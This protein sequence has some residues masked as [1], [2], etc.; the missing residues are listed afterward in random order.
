MGESSSSSFSFPPMTC[1]RGSEL[2]SENGVQSSAEHGSSFAKTNNGSIE[3]EPM[4]AD[5]LAS[6]L[7]ATGTSCSDEVDGE[8]SVAAIVDCRNFVAYNVNHV[9][10]AFNASCG[11]RIAQKRLLSGKATVADFVS[12]G[13]VPEAESHVPRDHFKQLIQKS[14]ADGRII[15]AYDDNATNITSLP[16]THPLRMVTQCLMKAGAVIKFL[17]GTQAKGQSVSVEFN[18]PVG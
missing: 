12:G 5:Q 7:P 17:H 16:A 11:D 13:P 9:T 14:A 10:S 1:C 3:V 18:R 15:V 2:P 4:S 6:S 8:Y